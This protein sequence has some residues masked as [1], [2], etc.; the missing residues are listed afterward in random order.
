[1]GLIKVVSRF[2]RNS[3]S[4]VGRHYYVIQ[5]YQSQNSNEHIR[6]FCL[7]SGRIGKKRRRGLLIRD[8]VVHILIGITVLAK[9]GF[10]ICTKIILRIIESVIASLSQASSEWSYS[11]SSRRAAYDCSDL[12]CARYKPGNND[13][14]VVD[15]SWSYKVF[16]PRSWFIVWCGWI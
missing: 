16:S 11:H 5:Y 15:R 6:Q 9:G 7:D 2:E 3:D 4:G 12:I 13:N 8:E 10:I 1:M 14:V